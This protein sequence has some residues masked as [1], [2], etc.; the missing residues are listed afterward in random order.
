MT[1]DNEYIEE[2][3]KGEPKMEEDLLTK[4]LEHTMKLYAKTDEDKTIFGNSFI[5]FG[6]REMRVINPT[7]IKMETKNGKR[8]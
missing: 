1:G 2:L 3:A 4:M 7:T 6:E 5:E 8:I